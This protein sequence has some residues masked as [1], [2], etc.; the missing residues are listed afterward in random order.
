ME[1]DQSADVIDE[2]TVE[3]ETVQNITRH[4]RA[5]IFMPEEV[6]LPILH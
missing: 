1:L 5:Q 4:H 6:D 3:L 2:R